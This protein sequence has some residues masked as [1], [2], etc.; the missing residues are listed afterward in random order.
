MTASIAFYSMK[1]T[2][3]MNTDNKPSG[4]ATASLILGICAILTSFTMT[5]IPPLILGSLAIILGLLSRGDGRRF[6]SYALAGVVTAASALVINVAITV[7]AFHLLFSNPE[8]SADYWNS[9]NRTYETMTG[10]SLKD[11]L[12]SY[13]IDANFLP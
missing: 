5:L 12:E 13:G 7:A 8:I 10:M 2:Y 3:F 11:I 1:G 6:H 9:V 4:F